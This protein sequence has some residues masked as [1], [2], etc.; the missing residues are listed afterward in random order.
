MMESAGRGRALWRGGQPEQRIRSRRGGAAPGTPPGLALRAPDRRRLGN[1]RLEPG[2]PAQQDASTPSTPSTPSP[3]T[4]STPPAATTETPGG[5]RTYWTT[6]RILRYLLSLVLAAVAISIVLGKRDELSGAGAYLDNLRWYWLVVAGAA[7][8]VSIMAYAAM[9]RRLLAAGTVPIGMVP[10]TAIAFAGNAIQNSLPG[11][12]VFSGVFGFRQFRKRGADDVLSGWVLV[13]TGALSQIAIIVLALVG[14]G[15]AEGT[16]SGFDLVWVILALV[17]LAIVM[18]V[19]WANRVGIMRRMAKPL[20]LVQRVLHR[21]QGDVQGLIDQAIRRMEAIT[22]S[23][24]DWAISLGY[25]IANWGLDICCLVCAFLAVGAEVPWRALVLSYGAAQLAA[26]LP[27]TPGGLGVVE[28]SLTIGLVAY[29]GGE[30]A[31]VAAV[32]VYR[33]ISFWALLP[34]GYICWALVSWQLRRRHA[35]PAL[36]PL[37]RQVAEGMA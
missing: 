20:R 32:L 9:E 22:P 2:A 30:S 31:T 36:A 11:G 27:I 33:L 25:A 10:L 14:L 4:P 37:E 3:P 16:G 35:G 5:I 34:V 13:A 19:A 24:T 28:G 7:E 23:R 21:P 1:P 15:A 26:N 6:G 17:V 29:G 8:L 18:V 12:P